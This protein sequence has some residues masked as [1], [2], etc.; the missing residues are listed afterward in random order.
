MEPKR[1]GIMVVREQMIVSRLCVLAHSATLSQKPLLK[2]SSC[3]PTSLSLPVLR[4]PGSTRTAR[5]C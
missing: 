3:L 4:C 1:K 2:H 5:T